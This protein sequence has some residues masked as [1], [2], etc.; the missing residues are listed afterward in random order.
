MVR[1]LVVTLDHII[2]ILLSLA[3]HA[4]DKVG[5][6]DVRNDLLGRANDTASF[7]VDFIWTVL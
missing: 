1:S 2:I 5:L 3:K 4:L 6:F 7:K